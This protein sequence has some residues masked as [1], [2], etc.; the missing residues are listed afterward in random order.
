MS[1]K[2]NSKVAV[3]TGGASGMG[4][5]TVERFIAEGAKVV[6]C[7]LPPQSEHDLQTRLGSTKAGMHRP[8]RQKGGAHDGWAIA[9]RLGSAAHFVPADVTDDLQLKAVF[10]A[11]VEQFGGVDILF[12]NAGVIAS[13]GSI[14][15]CSAEIFD[16]TLAVNLKSAWFGIKLAVPL[17]MARGGGSIISNASVAGLAGF[18]G[19]AAYSA[20][21]GGVISLTRA[22]AVE[23]A[24]HRIRVNCICPGAIVTPIGA[25]RDDDYDIDKLRERTSSVPLLPRAG[26]GA[27]I[28]GAALWLAS[29]DASFVTGQIITVDGGG[30]SEYD[31]RFRQRTLA[32]LEASS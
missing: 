32:K 28:A 23:L 10:D 11:A 14:A 13:E 5:S 2:L 30:I 27:D 25:A 9:D 4:L 1:G 17:L 31:A 20:S 29:D 21:K 26:E 8:G 15:D 19:M 24:G 18:G 3:I 7:D 22:A 6:F 16:H 12:N